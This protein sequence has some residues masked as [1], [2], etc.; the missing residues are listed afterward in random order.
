MPATVTLATT[1]LSE[2]VSA[3]AG[4]IKVASTSG[5]TPGTRLFLDGELLSVVSL[6][7]DPWVNVIRGVD[8]TGGLSHV[9]PSTIY[10]G[11]G[12]QFQSRNPTG[13][14]PDAIPVSPWINVTNGTVWFAVGDTSANQTGDRWWQQQT[15]T[16]STGPLGYPVKTLDP[17]VST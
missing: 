3:S 15:T 1:T 4:Q 13:R 11:R 9:A 5:L 7:V 14:P 8:G 16:Y 2:A 12:D 17:T 10:I 6:S